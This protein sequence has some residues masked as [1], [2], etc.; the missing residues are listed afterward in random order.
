M[1]D[2]TPPEEPISEVP[3]EPGPSE[4]DVVHLL[5]LYAD[6]LEADAAGPGEPAA[7]LN[8]STSQRRWS[9]ATARPEGKYLMNPK[10]ETE[11]NLVDISVT[12]EPEANSHRGRVLVGA[13]ALAAAAVVGGFLLTNDDAT[14][15]DVAD[16]VEVVEEEAESVGGEAANDDADTTPSEDNS[17]DATSPARED[18]A[19]D[20]SLG[21]GYGPGQII[22]AD[23]EFVSI[24][25]GPDG[26]VVSRSSDGTNWSTTDVDGI[27]SDANATTLARTDSGWATVVEVYPE[28]DESDGTASFFD[29]QVDPERWLAT[30]PNLIDWS[31]IELPDLQLDENTRSWVAGIAGAG[32]RIGIAMQVHLDGNDEYRILLDTGILDESDFENYCGSDFTEG[33]PFI[34]YTCSFGEAMVEEVA[35]DDA[36]LTPATTVP[37]EPVETFEENREELFRVVPGDPAYDEIAAMYTSDFE[38]LLQPA[39]V[40][41]GPLDG[42]FEVST[43]PVGGYQS[44]IVATDQGFV[45][46]VSNEQGGTVLTSPDGVAWTS[47]GGAAATTGFDQIAAS[48]DRLLALAISSGAETSLTEAWVSDDSGATWAS[49]TIDSELYGAFSML[50]GGP[51]GFAILVDGSLEPFDDPFTQLEALNIPKDGFTMVFNMAASTASLI[52]PDGETIHE[53]VG[54]DRIFSNG[55]E[56]VA[57]T[58]GEFDETIV[59]LDP[60]TGDDLVAIDESDFDAAFE[61]ATG[62]S[63]DSVDPGGVSEERAAELWFS[64]DGQ[65][66]TLLERL[67]SNLSS[68]STSL[69]AVGDDEVIIRTETLIEPPPELFE[70]EAEQRDPTD[71]EIEALDSFYAEQ[72]EGSVSWRSVPVG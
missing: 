8:E 37:T 61:A 57:R 70:F 33:G 19:A 67:E 36:P 66:W 9:Q 13:F 35:A 39:I 48:G 60:E 24:G 40:I 58:E 23:G 21:F 28:F 29:G 68:G 1:T 17:A 50:V 27:P 71:E 32:D 7:E 42:P 25:T 16:P 30:S 52:G 46:V 63:V 59:W 69:S 47:S 15:L 2:R 6:A 5:G 51:A 12:P 43:L 10:G 65:N 20:V 14:E 53:S 26:V 22:F 56:N 3:N 62:I 45:V 31:L 72:Q 38:D 4:A 18:E 55:T 54:L 34:G 64:D 11:Q 49:T 44:S 41:S